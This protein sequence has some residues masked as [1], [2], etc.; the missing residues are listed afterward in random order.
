V[1]GE[2]RQQV[3]LLPPCLD[4]YVTENN[5]VR[6][7]KPKHNLDQANSRQAKAYDNPSPMVA[8]SGALSA[9]YIH[10]RRA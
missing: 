5:P 10:G 8:G 1:E 2:A 6:V 7:R 3:V 4:D 9:R